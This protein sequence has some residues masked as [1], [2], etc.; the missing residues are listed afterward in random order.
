MTIVNLTVE[1]ADEEQAHHFEAFVAS[2]VVLKTYRILPSTSKMY[3]EDSFFRA[4]SKSLKK[5]KQVHSDYIHKHNDK[6][7]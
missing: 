7:S 3:T 1:C 4:I 2:Q 6:Y 5:S